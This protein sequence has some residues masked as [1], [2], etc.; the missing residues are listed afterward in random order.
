MVADAIQVLCLRS[1]ACYGAAG[2]LRVL[3]RGEALRLLAGVTL[4]RIVFTHQALPA[5]RPVRHLLDESGNIIVRCCRSAVL[6][7]NRSVVVGYQADAIDP[8]GRRGW[9]VVVVGPAEL[10]SDPAVVDGYQE[11]LPAVC[12]SDII[13]IHPELVNGYALSSSRTG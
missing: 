13:V 1:G 6:G 3:E 5:I 11:L 8:S 10:A 12:G 7:A 2:A 9:N 4:G